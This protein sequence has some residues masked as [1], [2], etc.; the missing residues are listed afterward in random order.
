[1]PLVLKYSHCLN[2]VDMFVLSSDF[3]ENQG[4]MILYS[5][6]DGQFLRNKITDLSLFPRDSL[7]NYFVNNSN[8]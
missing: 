1:M 5:F 7:Q 4:K 3:P 2:V 8:I 6:F